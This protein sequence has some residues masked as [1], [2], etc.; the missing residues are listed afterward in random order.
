MCVCTFS[1]EVKL[2]PVLDDGFI[3]DYVLMG[4]WSLRSSFTLQFMTN[5]FNMLTLAN[6]LLKG[7]EEFFCTN[8]SSLQ[9][10]STCHYWQIFC[11]RGARPPVMTL[12]NKASH[13]RGSEVWSTSCTCYFIVD[14]MVILLK[15]WSW[16][17][18]VLFSSCLLHHHETRN[19]FCHDFG[20][21]CLSFC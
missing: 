4:I 12:P 8:C 15:H 7:I 5:L 13:W 21:W 3:V 11:S 2:V 18:G 20:T 9:N 19:I 1:T 16:G 10:C 17:L 6:I 14:D